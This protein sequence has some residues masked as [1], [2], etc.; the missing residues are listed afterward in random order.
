MSPLD[1]LIPLTARQAECLD[2]IE[3]SVRSRGFPP[4]LREIASAMGIASTNGV[5]DHLKA[6][7]RKGRIER[8]DTSSRGI[9]V[10]G[11]LD[12]MSGERVPL[13]DETGK[14]SRRIAIDRVS[15]GLSPE[16]RVFAM[17]EGEHTYFVLEI[18]E[19]PATPGRFV[20]RRW[21]GRLSIGTVDGVL[22]GLVIAKL[23]VFP[24]PRGAGR[25]S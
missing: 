16:H 4:T 8:E 24:W 17:I 19:K 3:R 2:I 1:R 9:T 10:V 14:S 20:Y 5:N 15:M 18:S 23:H 25:S 13:F 11:L 22:V 12:E 21:C 7:E 6:L